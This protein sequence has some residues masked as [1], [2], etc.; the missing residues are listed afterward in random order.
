MD[1][2]QFS[3]TLKGKMIYS[4]NSI[5][6]SFHNTFQLQICFNV[7]F[8]SPVLH[9]HKCFLFLSLF[10]HLYF[11]FFNQHCSLLRRWRPTLFST[12]SALV[13]HRLPAVEKMFAKVQ[14]PKHCQNVWLFVMASGV[15]FHCKNMLLP[16]NNALCLKLYGSDLQ[17][18]ENR[19]MVVICIPDVDEDCVYT[20]YQYDKPDVEDALATLDNIC[21][22]ALYT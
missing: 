10:C 6:D 8:Q 11:L 21:G 18:N 20:E 2:K 19:N 16:G 7:L 4:S 3:S 5:C 14:G 13:T 15:L 1:C 12:T 9:F 17:S 22:A